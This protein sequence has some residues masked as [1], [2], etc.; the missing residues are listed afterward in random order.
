MAANFL[1]AGILLQL[2]IVLS[3]VRTADLNDSDEFDTL[4]ARDVLCADAELRP[5]NLGVTVRDHIAVLWGPVPSRDLSLRA[6]IRLRSMLPLANVRNELV[7][8][9][10]RFSAYGDGPVP[11][12]LPRSADPIPSSRLPNLP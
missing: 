3:P 11:R 12:F 10:N 9:E 1:H 8:S 5:L 2:L 7:V 4:E 6:E